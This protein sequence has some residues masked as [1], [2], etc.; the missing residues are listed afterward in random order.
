MIDIKIDGKGAEEAIRNLKRFLSEVDTIGAVLHFA[1]SAIW[2]PKI[3]SRL[4]IPTARTNYRDNLKKTMND[5]D[6]GLVSRAA[7]KNWANK[8]EEER[9]GYKE[10]EITNA[11]KEA[12]E[13]SEPMVGQGF[14]A[15]GIANMNL[16]NSLVPHIETG[17]YKIWQILQWGT[18]MY[19]PGD[20]KPIVR[21]GNQVFF[22]QRTQQGVMTYQTTNL[23]F[24]GREYFVQLD[25]DIHMS[26]YETV[27]FVIEYMQKKIKK[28]SY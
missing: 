13:P 8:T 2:V 12:I 9:R 19:D 28:Y 6:P 15:V 22:D 5:L 16:L 4:D 18:G 20:S 27:D 14:I 21:K 1:A 26:D 25:G 10:G 24:K 11:I 3:Q 23:G 7:T 17:K